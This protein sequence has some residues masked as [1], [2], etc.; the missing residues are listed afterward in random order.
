MEVRY[1]IITRYAEFAPDGTLYLIGGDHDK[2]IEESYPCVKNQVVAVTRVVLNRDDCKVDHPF[3]SFIIDEETKE[4]IA[5]GPSG[6]IP[7]LSMPD[8]V[9]LLGTG[10]VLG[11]HNVLIPKSGLYRVQFFIDD[12]VT[13]SVRFRVAPA[14]FFRTRHGMIAA[15]AESASNA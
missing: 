8:D 10:M 9:D 11:F 12:A 15:M 6:S 7:P 5:E 13:A 14:A 1:L 2:I 3:K 4:I